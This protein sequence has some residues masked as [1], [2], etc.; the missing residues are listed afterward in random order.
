MYPSL[1]P[2]RALCAALGA[3]FV[4]AGCADNVGTDTA[5][6]VGAMPDSLETRED[7]AKLR[8]LALTR[9]IA[10][11]L[12]EVL[13]HD[14]LQGACDRHFDRLDPETDKLPP[15]A[16]QDSDQ[17]RDML[18]CGKWIFFFGDFESKVA[19]PENI[20]RA[21]ADI[22]PDETG[23]S[24]S[25]LGFIPNPNEPG[26]PIGIARGSGN[27]WG[28]LGLFTGSPYTITCAACHFGQTPDG[29]YAVGMPNQDLDFGKFNAL[30]MFAAWQADSRKSD[31]ERW[32]EEIQ[33]YY[34]GLRSV[35]QQS[36]SGWRYIF[37]SSLLVSWLGAS[38][39]F[40]RVVGLSVPTYGELET[41]LHGDPNR[42]Y[43]SSP[44][45]PVQK[46]HLPGGMY[47]SSSLTFDLTHFAGDVDEGLVAPLASFI[48][49]D[50]LEDFIKAAYIFQTGETQ[51]TA[52]RYVDALATYLRVL[53]APKRP[54]PVDQALA[55]RGQEIFAS[56]CQSCHDSER[57]RSLEPIAIGDIGTP[58]ILL[59]PFVDYQPPHRLAEESYANYVEVL[60]PI[61]PRGGI[62]A[63]ALQGIWM[64]TELMLN[65]SV[66][67]LDHAFCLSKP[68]GERPDPRDPLTDAVHLDLCT[69]YSDEDKLALREFLLS[70]D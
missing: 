63:R 4:L 39:L 55:E 36:W 51:Y 19:F 62:H 22:F 68:R 53:T 33:T 44:F 60:G 34:Q 49:T 24:F 41:Y 13:E 57:G 15:E 50:E 2:G 3:T 56:N 14:A 37:D 31:P 26:F 20:V 58:E 7:I 46:D 5:N 27:P 48:P 40:Y 30:L 21:I 12:D 25:K 35:V 61:A 42:Y 18:L 59:D 64:K 38:E 67:D 8:Q 11:S 10:E 16:L 66:E 9:D 45:L 54:F 29:R 23:D 65:G 52:P 43:A 70:W 47:L 6:Q 32:P 28:A 1:R 69:D 17:L